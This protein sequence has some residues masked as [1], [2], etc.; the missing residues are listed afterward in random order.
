MNPEKLFASVV[1]MI[2]LL[3]PLLL[4]AA[5]DASRGEQVFGLCRVCHQAVGKEEKIGP[6]L[7]GL[8][9]KQKL[10]NGKAPTEENVLAVVDRGSTA[11]PAYEG[12]LS[13]QEKEDLLAYLKTL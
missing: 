9:Q 5:G 6:S 12:I 8:F 10:R 4:R 11:M 13:D 7:K 1:M 2:L 3:A